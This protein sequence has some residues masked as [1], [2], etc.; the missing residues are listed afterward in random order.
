MKTSPRSENKVVFD[1]NIK[2]YKQTHEPGV[3]GEKMKRGKVVVVTEEEAKEEKKLRKNAP[4]KVLSPEKLFKLDE[5][6]LEHRAKEWLAACDALFVD[7]KERYG[8]EKQKLAKVLPQQLAYQPRREY[9][10]GY[11]DVLTNDF[12]LCGQAFDLSTLHAVAISLY[13]EE[14]MEED[15]HR[16]S[17]SL[18]VLLHCFKSRAMGENLPLLPLVKRLTELTEFHGAP[19]NAWETYLSPI[20]VVLLCQDVSFLVR[21]NGKYVLACENLFKG[22][23]TL[24]D[25]AASHLLLLTENEAGKVL[26]EVSRRFKEENT[27]L[28]GL[29][30]TSILQWN[31][32]DAIV[33]KFLV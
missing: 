25:L 16:L 17:Y 4:F 22:A 15:F 31:E 18:A 6:E 8:Q 10:K 11:E 9:P 12:A 2:N 7:V 20:L 29:T 23:K 24:V 26:K 32:K 14:D 19:A 28:A 5:E 30:L 1:E 21:K 33:E 13:Q 27:T 3:T